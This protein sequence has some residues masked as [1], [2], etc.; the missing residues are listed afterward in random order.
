MLDIWANVQNGFFHPPVPMVTSLKKGPTG[1]L[2]TPQ[3]PTATFWPLMVR[4]EWSGQLLKLEQ[5]HLKLITAQ[6][7]TVF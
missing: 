3:W 4:M 5:F 1:V 6:E 7:Q 2:I